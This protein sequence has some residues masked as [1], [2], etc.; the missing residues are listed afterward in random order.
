MIQQPVLLDSRDPLN[1][2]SSLFSV[3]TTTFL[4]CAGTAAI[5]NLATILTK[6]RQCS[7][8]SVTMLRSPEASLS[9]VLHAS[10]GAGFGKGEVDVRRTDCEGGG[11]D[12]V[13]RHRYLGE[14]LESLEGKQRRCWDTLGHSSLGSGFL[15]ILRDSRQ[16]GR[17]NLPG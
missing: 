15:G 4:T 14:Q 11:S 5:T 2:K 13:Q 9:G 10:P 17:R 12:Q 8:L 6:N 1:F 7:E 3:E 16:L